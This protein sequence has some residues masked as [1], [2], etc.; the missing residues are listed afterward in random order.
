[1]KSF[2]LRLLGNVAVVGSIF[3]VLVAPFSSTQALSS[4]TYSF[5][6]T[7]A[8][9]YVTQG[10]VDFLGTSAAS[11]WYSPNW[12]Y[13]QKV[14]INKE[15]IGEELPDFPVLIRLDETLQD[16]IR[17]DRYDLVFTS[18]DG[19]T[20]LAHE[21]EDNT[22]IWVK[23]PKLIPEEDTILYIYYG[24]SNTE[25]QQQPKDLWGD[26]GAVYHLNQDPAGPTSDSTKNNNTGTSGGNMNANDSFI[27]ARIGKGVRFDGANNYIGAPHTSELSPSNA[28]TISAWT[29]TTTSGALDTIVD[30]QN[31]G[32]A[33]YDGYSLTLGNGFASGAGL[34]ALWCG[35]SDV[36]W[37]YANKKINDGTWHHLVGVIESDS[38]YIYIDGE[39][40]TVAHKTCNLDDNRANLHI[41]HRAD[42]L[43]DG[44]LNGSVD[45]V[46]ISSHVRSGAWIKAEY[47]NQSNS[48]DFL[49]LSDI[50]QT[51]PS[52]GSLQE[53]SAATITLK[54]AHALSFSAIS[55]FTPNASDTVTYQL[56]NDAGK[57]WLFYTKN[58]WKG[59]N[60]KN[61]IQRSSV[62]DING[63]L[64]NFPLGEGKLLWKA[65]LS[66]GT[67]LDQITV[68][69][70]P[71]R[72]SGGG[73]AKATPVTSLSDP[74]IAAINTLFE[75]AF[76][77]QP[78]YDEWLYWANRLINGEK[79]T[80][81]ELLGAMEHAAQH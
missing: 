56:S 30:K 62:A 23:V 3:A 54:P 74:R 60:P 76:K 72:V 18:R 43:Y 20:K 63:H 34:P 14:T 28:A 80:A 45:E 53:N 52:N 29:R 58:G 25:D 27:E 49:T 2:V 68:T 47:A 61:P 31:A 59:A 67:T 44:A 36:N 79:D 17:D 66:S 78:T 37:I 13:R 5:T 6:P 75:T 1:M 16:N 70:S 19:T 21:V 38:Q 22:T 39:L 9:N 26:Y 69:Y 48:E 10:K 42:L 73:V 4:K 77:R 55:S 41:G 71:A 65:Y 32:P 51:Y 11:G 46:R 81:E 15:F 40:N 12:K 57:T 50:I 7:H 24:N 8:K 64:K 35:A 33:P